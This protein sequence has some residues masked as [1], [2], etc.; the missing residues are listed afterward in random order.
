M[1]HHSEEERAMKT[2]IKKIRLQTRPVLLLQATLL[3]LSLPACTENKP[4]TKSSYAKTIKTNMKLS[5]KEKSEDSDSIKESADIIKLKI[6]GFDELEKQFKEKSKVLFQKSFTDETTALGQLKTANEDLFCR[7]DELGV[8]SVDD[9]FKLDDISSTK[10]DDQF[11]I[12]ESKIIF[13]NSKGP[14]TFIC[15]HTTPNLFVESFANLFNEYID[16]WGPSNQV[17]A[18]SKF[19][20]PKTLKRKLNAIKI[21]NLDNL[22]KASSTEDKGP[23]YFFF[24]GQIKDAD[25]TLTLIKMGQSKMG[26]FMIDHSEKLATDKTYISVRRG[27]Y[28]G[29]T[30][31]NI[32][33]AS[34]YMIYR[35]DEV[36]YFVLVCEVNKSVEWFE[37]MPTMEGTLQFGALERLQYNQVYDEVMAIQERIE[38]QQNESKN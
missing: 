19:E 12:Y 26:C 7:A 33:S 8:F 31:K 6:K 36:N 32:P 29:D 18:D 2:I 20:N 25:Q 27:L 24:D 35:A 11:D 13:K 34:L 30:P 1:E 10:K 5:S 3:A 16:V 23:S 37:L 22:M 14:L 4:T 28:G 9:Y 21:K 17:L 15:T 38:A